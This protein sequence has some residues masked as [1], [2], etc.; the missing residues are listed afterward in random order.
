MFTTIFPP[1]IGGPATQSF[2]LCKAL[3]ECGVVPVVVTYGEKFGRTAPD[4]YPLYAFR[5]FYGLG[6]LDRVIRWAVF[7]FYIRSVLKKEKIDA[8][9]CHSVNML[10]FTAA[11]IAKMMG[12]PRVVK[13]AGDWVWETLSTKGIRAEDFEAIYKQSIYSRF[14]TAI[15]RRGLRLFNAIWTPSDFRKKNVEYLL[16]EKAPIVQIP[17]CLLIKKEIGK[18]PGGAEARREKI[19][20]SANRFIPHKRVPLLVDMFAGLRDKTAKLVL[21]GGGQEAIV[22]EVKARIEKWGIKDRVTLTGV[23][24][25][26]EIY[27][28]FKSAAVYVSNSLEEGF[29]NVFIEAMACGLPIVSTDIGGSR[30]LVLEGETGFLKDVSDIEGLKVRID[31]ILG[32]QKLRDRLGKNAKERSELFDLEKW[33]PKFIGLYEGLVET[34]R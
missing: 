28:I 17:N 6:P 9:H 32:D 15:E 26:A 4:G 8:L 18:T 7:P 33:T 2:H 10:S 25:K 13:F 31:E 11:F 21:I 20:V 29:P 16:G 24:P 30:E 12:I 14:L 22:S 27:K 3:L 23:L 34:K 5:R 19:V 1:A